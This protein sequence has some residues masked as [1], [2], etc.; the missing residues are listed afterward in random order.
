MDKEFLRL[1]IN[2]ERGQNLHCKTTPLLSLKQSSILL[3]V[4]TTASTS[5]MYVT[6]HLPLANLIGIYKR[7][8]EDLALLKRY[9]SP[10]TSERQPLSLGF[11]GSVAVEKSTTSRLLQILLSRTFEGPERGI[12]NNGWLPIQMLS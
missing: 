1:K 4:L 11:Q 2:R 6:L 3:K 10:K 9:F 7:S 12:G 8:K 5:R